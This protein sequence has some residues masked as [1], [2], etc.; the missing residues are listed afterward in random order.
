MSGSVPFARKT[1]VSGVLT[2][3]SGSAA[4]A[5]VPAQPIDVIR[6]GIVLTTATT[7]AVTK[8]TLQRRPIAGTAANEV[9]LAEF[10]VPVAAAGTVH[11]FNLT[12]RGAINPGED[13][14]MVSNNGSSAG[15]GH[16]FMEYLERP[17]VGERIA[18][19]TL[20]A[21]A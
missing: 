15:A 17:F 7:A 13:V 5:I 2:I 19:A 14:R 4:F 1:E 6:V 9:T 8:L 10:N 12:A 3:S 20:A 18:N 16:M 11:Y 21:A